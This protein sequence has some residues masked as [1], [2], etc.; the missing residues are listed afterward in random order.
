ELFVYNYNSGKIVNSEFPYQVHFPINEC[1]FSQNSDND[2]VLY[3]RLLSSTIYELSTSEPT[4]ILS[5][6]FGIDKFDPDKIRNPTSLIN[7]FGEYEKHR[8]E[9]GEYQILKALKSDS[10]V[11]CFIIHYLP[12]N[13]GIEIF[14]T[15][16][17][18]VN[19]TTSFLAFN[20]RLKYNIRPAFSFHENY[21]YFIIPFI[22]ERDWLSQINN[23]CSI[24]DENNENDFIL[25]WE[26]RSE[27]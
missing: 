4:S 10:L 1:P 16:F 3:R 8:R 19:N 26:V 18:L 2:K 11:Y 15:L 12:E 14:H 7:S 24:V 25:I 21:L 5:I 6:N 23:C 9:H 17:D 20:D 27:E 22:E 13:R